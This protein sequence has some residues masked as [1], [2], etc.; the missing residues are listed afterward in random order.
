VNEN[1]QGGK[2]LHIRAKDLLKVGQLILNEGIW[3]G[4]E[5]LNEEWIEQSFSPQSRGHVY[6]GTYGLHWWLKKIETGPKLGD[7]F[8][9]WAAIGFG[10]NFLFIVP[11]WDLVVVFTGHLVG[12]ENFEFPQQLFKDVILTHPEILKRV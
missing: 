2:G 1:I 4:K 12:A 6:Y 11:E 5:L 9:V 10:G 3:E 7:D 8:N